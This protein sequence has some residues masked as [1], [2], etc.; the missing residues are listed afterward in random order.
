MWTTIVSSLIGLAI[1]SYLEFTH[2]QPAAAGVGF[3]LWLISAEVRVLAKYCLWCSGVHLVTTA[4]LI[5]L[6]RVS[7]AQLGWVSS[8]E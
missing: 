7:P 1:S 3:V 2:F 6:T 5:V 8:N 4:L